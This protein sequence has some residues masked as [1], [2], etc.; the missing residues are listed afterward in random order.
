MLGPISYS[1]EAA[2]TN[3]DGFLFDDDVGHR[4]LG[5]GWLKCRSPCD[6]LC[7]QMSAASLEGLDL[8]GEQFGAI[9]QK[10]RERKGREEKEIYNIPAR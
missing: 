1:G 6:E 2:G 3:L 8:N 9:D 4:G 10:K 7:L 5:R